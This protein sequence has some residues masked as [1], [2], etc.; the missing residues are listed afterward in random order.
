[1]RSLR[2]I[3]AIAVAAVALTATSDAFAQRN[4][5]Q[6]TTV[7]VINYQRVVAESAIGRDMAAK[8]QQVR[9][10]L[11]TEAQSLAPEQQSIE[12]ERQRLAQASRN[13]S[14]EQIRNSSTLAPQ[15]EQ[16]THRLQ[17]FQARTQGLQGDF[18]CSQALALRDFDRQVSPIVRSVMEARGAGVVLDASNIQLV[19]PDFDVTNTVIQQL[20]QNQATRSATV[21]RHALTECQAQQPAAQPAPAQ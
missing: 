6:A 17:Q 5:N 1:M 12:Q 15:F 21:A 16:F 7:V 4:R 8:L 9:T 2:V 11:G 3:S 14:P 19:L 20:D 13:L 18:E 10:Q